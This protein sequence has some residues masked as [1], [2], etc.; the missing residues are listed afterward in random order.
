ML[1]QV[2]VPLP[3][4]TIPDL[5]VPSHIIVQ[6]C[7]G[8]PKIFSLF[9]LLCFNFFLSFFSSPF[10]SAASHLIVQKWS[11]H[12]H[13]LSLKKNNSLTPIIVPLKI[14]SSSSS[15]QPQCK[16]FCYFGNLCSSLFF[17]RPLSQFIG[18][19]MSPEENQGLDSINCFYHIA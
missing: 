17:F 6:R 15:L 8:Q 14:F 10:L 4:N 7:S 19:R 3:A 9:F 18:V 13:F 11:G 1:L 5:I 16:L 12:F 2:P